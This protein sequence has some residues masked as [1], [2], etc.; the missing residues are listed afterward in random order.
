MR[1]YTVCICTFTYFQEDPFVI[2]FS[3][4]SL[5]LWVECVWEPINTDLIYIRL[6]KYIN[7]YHLALLI[8]KLYKNFT[9]INMNL[10]DLKK[11]STLLKYICSRKILVF[12]FGALI[13]LTVWVD[14]YFHPI[15]MTYPIQPVPFFRAAP[16]WGKPAK[17]FL[18]L[19]SFPTG[20]TYLLSALL[21]VAA[22][23]PHEESH[24][25][26]CW[27]SPTFSA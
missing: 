26:Y 3:Y 2:L 18:F 22:S 16:N 1:V 20:Q 5:P 7:G 17:H 27:V 13:D 23:H 24:L 8:Y 25:I 11:I 10:Y 12:L 4:L 15:R 21:L 14:A 9:I 19:R 6:Y